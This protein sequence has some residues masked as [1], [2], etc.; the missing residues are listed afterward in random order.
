MIPINNPQQLIDYGKDIE[1]QKE[2]LQISTLFNSIEKSD[3]T[4]IYNQQLK[5][6][7]KLIDSYNDYQQAINA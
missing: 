7:N 4:E 1:R 2:V 6:V 3:L 5:I